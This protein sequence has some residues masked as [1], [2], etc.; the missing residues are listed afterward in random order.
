MIPGSGI[1][2]N[3]WTYCHYS[4]TIDENIDPTINIHDALEKNMHIFLARDIADDRQGTLPLVGNL[5]EAGATALYHGH[6][7]SLE[8]QS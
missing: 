7:V 5:D 2:I 1:H 6:S 8:W 4:C 3:K